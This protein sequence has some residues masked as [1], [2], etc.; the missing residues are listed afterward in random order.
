MYTLKYNHA[1]EHRHESEI[2]LSQQLF[3]QCR[4]CLLGRRKH[5]EAVRAC[6]SVAAVVHG[7]SKSETYTEVVL[8]TVAGLVSGDEEKK[9]NV[10]VRV[11]GPRLLLSLRRHICRSALDL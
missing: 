10:E 3:F 7:R 2:D 4:I 8:R 1:D 11:L 5:R 9:R 6:W